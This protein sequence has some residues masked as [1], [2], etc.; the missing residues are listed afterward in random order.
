[1][2]PKEA[3]EFARIKARLQ[4]GVTFAELK[5]LI[6]LVEKLEQSKQSK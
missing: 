4:Y 6:A 2:T 3:K 1:M 5:W